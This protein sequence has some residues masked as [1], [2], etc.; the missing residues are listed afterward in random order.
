M[1][2]ENDAYLMA[3]T[4]IGFFFASIIVFIVTMVFNSYGL[5]ITYSSLNSM[6][7]GEF[8]SGTGEFVL[9]EKVDKGEI[10]SKQ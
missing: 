10:H 7:C 4:A 2:E 1:T 3:G 8:D 5:Y 6:G 9:P